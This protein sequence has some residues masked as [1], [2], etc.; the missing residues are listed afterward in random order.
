[1]LE[2]L[3]ATSLLAESQGGTERHRQGG[4]SMSVHLFLGSHCRTPP[5]QLKLIQLLPEALSSNT[6]EC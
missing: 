5:E 4:M 1:M 6:I 3:G 2:S